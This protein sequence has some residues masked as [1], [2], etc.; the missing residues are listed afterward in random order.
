MVDCNILV[1]DDEG[2]INEII[3][4][5]LLQAGYKPKSVFTL[6]Q[7]TTEL[8]TGLYSLVVL[9]LSLPD[10]DG[11]ELLASIV[12]EHPKLPVIILSAKSKADEVDRGLELGA[13][14]YMSKP[15]RA[16]ELVLR[17]NNLIKNSAILKKSYSYKNCNLDYTLK[18]VFIE[19]KLIKLNNKEF[20]LMHILMVNQGK[21]VS[22]GFVYE[23]IWGSIEEVDYH[24]LETTLSNLRRKLKVAG[25][26]FIR[27]KPK[28]GY[29]LD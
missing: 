15:F 12:K 5:S 27:T 7:A 2:D 29:Y 1:V 11:L 10:G 4:S 24:R 26:D 8:K 25:V 22:R 6:K 19:N 28:V 23:N 21:V 20:A 14:D 13:R 16:K 3:S 9:D 17:V 18:K